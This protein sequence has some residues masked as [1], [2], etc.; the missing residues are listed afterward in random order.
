MLDAFGREICYMRIS[1]TD[2][3]NLRCGYCM[4]ERFAGV[5]HADVLRYEELLR[6]CRAALTLGVDRFKITGG[7]PLVRKGV[8]EF[9][10]RLKTLEGVRSVTLTTNGL[11]LSE[12][13]PGLIKA[14][15]DGV[16]VSLD[17]VDRD[18]YKRITGVDAADEVLSAAEEC[19]ASGIRTKI[20]AVVM[21]SNAGQ[22]VPLASLAG[23][24]PIDVRFIELMPIGFGA[25]MTAPDGSRVLELLRQRW[26][27]LSPAGE[28]RGNGPA[29]YFSA[30]GLT[31]R[32]G[33]IA[34]SSRPFCGSC[35][36]VRL[37]STGFLKPCLCYSDG[38][39]L[40]G[41]LRGGA[42]DE[43]LAEAMR[44]AILAKPEGHSFGETGGVTESRTMCQIGG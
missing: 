7:E 22:I 40:R 34:A 33:V 19:A 26:P 38:V 6:I 27:E 5:S 14:G 24:L 23:R 25:G 16:N 9:I 39:D 1:V 29:E 36:R 4:P 32:I 41:L 21:E 44:K 3:C 2:R 20:N 35:N 8:I 42:D 10:A 11:L 15:I 17:A 13:L 31:G 28:T 18:I 30:D 12:A 37:T 43:A